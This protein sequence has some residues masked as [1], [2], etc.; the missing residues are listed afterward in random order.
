MCFLVSIGSMLQEYEKS[1]L[2][3]ILSQYLPI[4]AWLI[5][6]L[7]ALVHNEFEWL[8]YCNQELPLTF[9]DLVGFR[10]SSTKSR[11]FLLLESATWKDIPHCKRTELY[12]L[13]LQKSQ[14]DLQEKVGMKLKLLEFLSIK[15]CSGHF[16]LLEK[17]QNSIQLLA[18]LEKKSLSL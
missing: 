7:V 15:E 18:F 11:K 16:C 17:S 14:E 13:F 4:G 8:K 9:K 2:G 5:V 6:A 12:F 3:K 10:L 1:F